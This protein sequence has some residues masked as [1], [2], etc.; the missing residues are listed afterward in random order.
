M[1]RSLNSQVS[2][3]FMSDNEN[4]NMLLR[5]N[6]K[7]LLRKEIIKQSIFIKVFKTLFLTYLIIFGNNGYIIYTILNKHVLMRRTT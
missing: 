7:R 2:E 4:H 6:N 5:R 1:L 3:R